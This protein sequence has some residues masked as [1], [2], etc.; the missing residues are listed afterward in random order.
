MIGAARRE[1]LT[2]QQPR[3]FFVDL[4]QNQFDP[5]CGNR[6]R[7]HV[8]GADAWRPVE[9]RQQ[10]DLVI[11][12]QHDCLQPATMDE[13]FKP[14]LGKLKFAGSPP[15]KNLTA[16]RYLVP[17]PKARQSLDYP[18][19][20]GQSRMSQLVGVQSERYRIAANAR[21]ARA[22]GF[23][24]H[25]PRGMHST[26]GRPKFVAHVQRHPRGRKAFSNDE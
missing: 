9:A 15:R 19:S 18:Q 23:A 20:H 3:R 4:Q 13:P 7:R 25:V 12:I 6:Q 1:P 16:N 10:G 11:H 21:A 14:T 17:S 24:G 5:R 22:A 8:F 2:D 26:A